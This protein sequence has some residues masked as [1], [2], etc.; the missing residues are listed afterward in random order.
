MSIRG[1]FFQRASTLKIQLSVQSGPHP[2]LIENYL[3]LA[4]IELKIAELAL[5]NNHSLVIFQHHQRITFSFHTS[6]EEGCIRS[7]C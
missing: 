3:V 4:M 5:S 2:H 1:L 6:F 7:F